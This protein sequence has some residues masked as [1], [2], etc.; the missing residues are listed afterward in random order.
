[1]INLWKETIEVLEQHGKSFKDV[2]SVYGKDF[3]ITLENF[4][5]LAKVTNYDVGY[6]GQEVA[7]DLTLS[8]CNFIMKRREYD[9]SE[10]W[11][12]IEIPG[13]LDQQTTTVYTLYSNV[14][15]WKTLKDL[16]NINFEGK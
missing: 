8:G 9:G 13:A 3:Q 12:Y 11:E 15:N 2:K 16:N 10:W 14:Y 6:G 5:N 4:E 1:M 7:E